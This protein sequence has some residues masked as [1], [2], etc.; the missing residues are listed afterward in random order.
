MCVTIS[1]IQSQRCN[2]RSLASA[3]ALIRRSGSSG[4]REVYSRATCRSARAL[5]RALRSRLLFGDE[6]SADGKS[7]G[8]EE[9]EEEAGSVCNNGCCITFAHDCCPS[10]NPE[11][12]QCCNINHPDTRRCMNQ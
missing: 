2:V 11:F 12:S 3:T 4:C 8:D 10:P 6:E 1:C 9:E 5:W 7:Q